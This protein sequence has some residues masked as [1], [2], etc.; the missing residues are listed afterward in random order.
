MGSKRFIYSNR[1]KHYWH[2]S[3]SKAR[4]LGRIFKVLRY[5]HKVEEKEVV[6]NRCD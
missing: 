2:L 6:N 5:S 3:S 1:S 4:R